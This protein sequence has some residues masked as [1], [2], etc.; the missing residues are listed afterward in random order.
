MTVLVS[1]WLIISCIGTGLLP[2]LYLFFNGFYLLVHLF[3]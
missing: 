1:V 2:V 3:V